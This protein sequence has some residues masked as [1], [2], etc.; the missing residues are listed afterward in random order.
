MQPQDARVLF[1]VRSRMINLRAV[2][3]YMHEDIT[4]RLCGGDEESLDHVLNSCRHIVQGGKNISTT[5]IYE[6]DSSINK[7]IVERIKT[8]LK[9]VSEKEREAIS[10][11]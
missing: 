10:E 1:R 5:N 7:D 9:L 4:C 3:H 11:E 2:C 8:F 6:Q